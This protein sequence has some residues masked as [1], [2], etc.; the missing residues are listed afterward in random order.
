MKNPAIQTVVSIAFA[1]AIAML[2]FPS[3]VLHPG[4]TIPSI[5]GDGGKNT[6]TYLYHSLYGQG[7]W[8]TGMN[9]PYGEHITYT[10]GQPLISVNL[11]H[12]GHISLP[13]AMSVLLWCFLASFMLSIVFINRILLHFKVHPLIALAASGLIGVMAPQVFGIGGHYALGYCCVIPMLF[14]WTIR[15]RE[16]AHWRYPLYFFLLGITTAFLHPYFWLSSFSGHYFTASA[17]SLPAKK[18]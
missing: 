8:F 16:N 10:D 1:L 12:L 2:V 7:T 4:H 3:V 5:W 18:I 17:I 13:Q 14:Y 6:F 11:G 9:Y 15:Y